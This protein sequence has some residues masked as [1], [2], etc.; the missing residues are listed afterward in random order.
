MVFQS[1]PQVRIM[2]SIFSSSPTSFLTFLPPRGFEQAVHPPPSG[3]SCFRQPLLCTPQPHAIII[4]MQI[5]GRGLTGLGA[6]AWPWFRRHQPDLKSL[7]TMP[8]ASPSVCKMDDAANWREL[9][10]AHGTACAPPNNNK[11]LLLVLSTIL[12]LLNVVACPPC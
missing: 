10:D 7:E 3:N 5:V 4:I 11:I 2:T 6:A 12:R 9:R 8:I 1:N